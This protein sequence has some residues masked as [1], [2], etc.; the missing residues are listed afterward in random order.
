VLAAPRKNAVVIHKAEIA[1]LQRSL[2]NEPRYSTGLLLKNVIVTRGKPPT[3]GK[4]ERYI[5]RVRRKVY[6]GT[7]KG[8]TG[9]AVSTVKTAQLLEYGASHQP[10][11]PWIRPAFESRAR[12]AIEVV[13]NE[14]N[15]SIK[16]I[17][18]KLAKSN[19]PK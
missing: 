17:V 9:K 6:P 12:E 4:G 10:P 1:N 2:A 15:K 11:E 8:G 7:G 3:D 18:D 14:L 19:R 5:V 16:R 13:V